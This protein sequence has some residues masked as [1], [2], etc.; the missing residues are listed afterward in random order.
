M[1][2]L[3]GSDD[4]LTTLEPLRGAVG[5]WA[6]FLAAGLKD[7]EADDLRKHERTGRPLGDA[8]FVGELETALGRRL[9]PAKRGRKKGKNAKPEVAEPIRP[10][11]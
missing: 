2:H 11:F 3:D 1:A 6:A 7:R 4:G 5:G 9:R 8:R 10:A